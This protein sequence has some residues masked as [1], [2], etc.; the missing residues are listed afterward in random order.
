MVSRGLSQAAGLL[1]LAIGSAAF[2]PANLGNHARSMNVQSPVEKL[3]S[4][5]AVLSRMGK[6]RSKIISD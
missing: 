4:C 6:V 3:E 5:D 1:L 2:V